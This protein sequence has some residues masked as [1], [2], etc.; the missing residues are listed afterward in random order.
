[1][2]RRIFVLLLGIVIAFGASSVVAPAKASA[3]CDPSDATCAAESI[4]D[5][6]KHSLLGMPHWYKYLEIGNKNGDPCAITGP[7]DSDGNFNWGVAAPRVLVA[8]V[9]IL[10]RVAALVAVAF[11]LY[12]GFRYI[13]SQGE[14]DATKKAKGTIVGASVGLV[15]TMFASIIVG[16]VGRVLWP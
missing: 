1:M 13:L 3:A 14:P 12:G 5:A 7:V 15:I 8:V 4:P 9:E 16:L 2:R 10:L 6:C 11:T